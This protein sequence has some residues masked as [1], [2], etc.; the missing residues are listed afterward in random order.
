M[1]FAQEK[2]GI[3]QMDERRESL[4]PPKP[5]QIVQIDN[6]SVLG[7]DPADS[8]FYINFSEE[9]RTVV[10]HKVDVRLVPMLAILYLI[11]HIDRAN[12]GVCPV[13]SYP[14]CPSRRD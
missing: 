2:S 11:S 7:I 9:K 8:E 5:N 10:I 6:F 4:D 3:H 1:S 14:V 13:Q 12:I